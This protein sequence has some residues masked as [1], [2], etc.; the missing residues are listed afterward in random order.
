MQMKNH[1]SPP[2]YWCPTCPQAA[3]VAPWPTPCSLYAE[4]ASYGMKYPFGQ[5]GSAVPAAPPP[6]FLRTSSILA[7]RAREAEESL[8]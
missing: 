5:F 1:S 8:T 2:P 7:D 4:M 6:R 3:V